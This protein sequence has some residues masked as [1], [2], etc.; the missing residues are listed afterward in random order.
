MIKFS[1]ERIDSHRVAESVLLGKLLDVILA[2]ARSRKALWVVKDLFLRLLL[3]DEKHIAV[4][5][6]AFRR[7]R[8]DVHPAR[9][10]TPCE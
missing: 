4:Q 5:A 3:I 7:A 8:R 1:L 10:A 9:E 6:R 2:T